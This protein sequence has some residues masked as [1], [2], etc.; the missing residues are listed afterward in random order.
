MT[1][2]VRTEALLVYVAGALLLPLLGS[3]CQDDATA[4][5]SD[6][7]CR[8]CAPTVGGETSDFGGVVGPCGAVSRRVAIEP[9]DAKLH[10][11]DA[12]RI[13]QLIRREID[14]VLTWRP[15]PVRS[16]KPA[17]GFEPITRVRGKVVTGTYSHYRPDP[18]FCDG[19]TCRRE[20]VDV[21]QG[22]CRHALYVEIEAGL[23][24]LDGSIEAMLKGEAA[25][26]LRGDAYT[27]ANLR[28]VRGALRLSPPPDAL[29][30]DPGPDATRR[31]HP[32]PGTL[33]VKLR[34]MDEDTYGT[35]KLSIWWQSIADGG[36]WGLE[37][38]APLRAT[39]PE[40]W[41]ERVDEEE[42]LEDWEWD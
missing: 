27:Y 40:E 41:T 20:D 7:V 19:V 17:T 4:P 42:D 9:D 22:T 32:F 8:M 39:W 10:G 31:D 36:F 1:R 21:Q 15:H 35:M 11:F 23:K 16:G 38:Y 25:Q 18:E 3:A 34:F 2:C 37:Q 14:A 12:T 29:D 6:S 26:W 30:D 5:S 33:M 28:D 13:E 24:T